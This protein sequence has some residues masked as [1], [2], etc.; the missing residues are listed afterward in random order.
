V[1]YT[2]WTG[3]A[4]MNLGVHYL[5]DVLAGYAVG[6]GVAYGVY[7]L[8]SELFDATEPFLP[9]QPGTP[10]IGGVGIGMNGSTPLVAF[11]FSF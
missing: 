4:R 10:S 6:A 7:L 11:S 8:R 2:L 3:F 9:G 5:T 1:G